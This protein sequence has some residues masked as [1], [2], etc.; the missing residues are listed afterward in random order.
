M[1]TVFYKICLETE[2]FLIFELIKSVEIFPSV[3]GSYC[4]EVVRTT[5]VVQCPSVHLYPLSSVTPV[6]IDVAI[7]LLLVFPEVLPH[8]FVS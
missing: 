5:W 6:N 8:S 4:F 2:N 3:D 7:G 1:Q